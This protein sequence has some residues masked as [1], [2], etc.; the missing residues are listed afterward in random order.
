MLWYQKYEIVIQ[1]ESW[2]LEIFF[3]KTKDEREVIS[4]EKDNFVIS[5]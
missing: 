4:R 5:T 1:G 2:D 3:T